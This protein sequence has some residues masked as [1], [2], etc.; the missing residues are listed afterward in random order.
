MENKDTK[1][2]YLFVKGEK[3]AV[4]EEVYRAYVRADYSAARSQRRNS[5]C[6]VKGERKGLVR[7]KRNCEECP[8][9]SAGNKLLG[10]VLSLDGLIEEGYE[11]VADT[12]IENDLIVNEENDTKSK[13][14]YSA[15]EKLTK[16][17][18]Y[19]IREIYFNGKSQA[20]L[21]RI[22]NMEKSAMSKTVS[23]AL[24]TL[25]KFLEKF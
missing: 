12:D 18:R 1:Q 25:R 10:G 9:Y 3:V 17:Q 14:L 15:M 7:C 20:E 4:S 5:K 16:R 19:I 23:R 13:A 22:F 24:K 11:E 8:Y 2:F 21:C 6:L